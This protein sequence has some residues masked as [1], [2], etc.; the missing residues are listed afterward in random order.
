M[1]KW[2][3]KIS[4]NITVETCNYFNLVKSPRQQ[5]NMCIRDKRKTAFFP[6]S[7][8][9]GELIR[10]MHCR[11]Y[12]YQLRCVIYE[13][14][15]RTA[16]TLSADMDVFSNEFQ[17]HLC[18]SGGVGRIWTS[19]GYCATKA[20]YT[21]AGGAGKLTCSRIVAKLSTWMVCISPEYLLLNIGSLH[22]HLK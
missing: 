3:K 18:V 7:K 20:R 13:Q 6:R 12:T 10:G 1:D 22:A 21:E 14:Q 11:K 8:T 19:W 2:V 16:V 5:H 17:F 15:N 4:E 9:N